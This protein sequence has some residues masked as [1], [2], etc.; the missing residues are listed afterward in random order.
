MR[1]IAA[2][3]ALWDKRVQNRLRLIAPEVLIENGDPSLLS[4]E[5][6]KSLLIRF[7]EL[8]ADCQYTGTSFDITMVRRLADPQLASTVNDLLKKYATHDD[9]CKLLLKLI[10]QGQISES[11]D[12]ALSYAID[13][14]T[15]SYIRTCAIR[16]VAAAGTTEQHGKLLNTLLADISKLS[17]NTIGEVCKVFFPGTMSVSQ[18][19]K[20]LE[21]ATPPERYSSS[22][23]QQSIEETA[24]T[25]LPEVE[26]EKLLRGLHKLLKNQ[27]FID[28]RHCKISA[29]YAWLLPSAIRLANQFIQKKHGFS[30][31]PI[32]LDL[33]LGLFVAQNLDDFA[34]YDR[35]KIITDAKAWSEFRYQLLWHAIATARDREKDSAKHSI[36]WW[37]IHWD[38]RDFW[39]TSTDDLERLF[40][41]LIHKPLMDDR[42]I[43]LTVVFAV[44]LDEGRP[45][46]LR[47][48]MKRMVAGTPE[49]EAKLH[50]LLHPKPLSK[51]QKKWRQDHNFKQRRKERESARKAP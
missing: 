4:I 41:D 11:V 3:L 34:T 42:S 14:H 33:F 9:V 35:D 25:V 6:R 20:I 10:W 5:F 37:Q 2:W 48:R 49:L 45:R 46:Q 43:A 7:A 16:G 31:D 30:F 12:A 29:K 19:L 13:D 50:E 23:L 15:S 27:P 32:V 26:A 17:S 18:L 21:T 47:E 36:N 28:R 39:V 8:Y 22:Q 1:P 40:E 24:S 44:Y 51:E 38:V